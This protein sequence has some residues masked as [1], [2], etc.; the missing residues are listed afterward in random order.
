MEPVHGDLQD[1]VMMSR[2]TD[3][4]DTEVSK[5]KETWHSALTFY[6]T[7]LLLVLSFFKLL[8]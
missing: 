1:D 7:Q 4:L 3:G 2:L 8:N 5:Q 6:Q